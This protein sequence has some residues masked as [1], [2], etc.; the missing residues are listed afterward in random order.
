MNNVQ[1]VVEFLPVGHV[2]NRECFNRDD[3]TSI[4]WFTSISTI[5]E[6]F[7]ILPTSDALGRFPKEEML[8][9]A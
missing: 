2:E 5:E 9:K 4:H 3:V 7:F 1:T 8:Y 6:Q